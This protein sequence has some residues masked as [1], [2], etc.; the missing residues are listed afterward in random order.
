MTVVRSDGTDYFQS[1]IWYGERYSLP[2]QSV[3]FTRTC[4]PSFFQP[5]TPHCSGYYEKYLAQFTEQKEANEIFFQCT[6]AISPVY[7]PAQ[8]LST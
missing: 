5:Y 4:S 2:I 3:P 6:I 1:E 7:N 8:V